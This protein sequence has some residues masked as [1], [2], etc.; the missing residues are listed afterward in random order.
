MHTGRDRGCSEMGFLAGL[1]ESC[2]K[3]VLL[4]GAG[5]SLMEKYT[6]LE[7]DISALDGWAA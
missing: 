4:P 1:Q 5:N 7:T 2:Y 6:R 3:P